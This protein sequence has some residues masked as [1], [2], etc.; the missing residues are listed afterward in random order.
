MKFVLNLI[1]IDYLESAAKMALS[2]VVLQ[3]N[4]FSIAGG[5]SDIDLPDVAE[6]IRARGVNVTLLWDRFCRDEEIERLAEQLSGFTENISSVRFADPGVGLF[7]KRQLPELNLQ[8]L[9]WDGHQNRSGI[10]KWINA[11]QPNLQRLIISNQISVQSI[12][13]LREATSTNIEIKGLGRFQLFYSE[14][15][16]L[17]NQISE[18]PG[19][20][21]RVTVASMDRPTQFFPVQETPRSTVIFND[22]DLFLLDRLDDLE[23]MGI[24]YVGLEPHTEEQYQLLASV[25]DLT[26]ESGYIREIWDRPLTSGFFD[27]NKTDVLLEKLTNPFL[28]DEKQQQIATVLESY[29]NSHI[30]I[31]LHQKLE[32]PCQVL[33]LTPE[34]KTVSHRIAGLRDLQGK[35]YWKM[36][37]KGFYLLPWIKFVVPASIM[38][39]GI[40]TNY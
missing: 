6:Q 24:D 32:L 18:N 27:E 13:S 7:L 23:K 9:M 10:I 20:H 19:E 38:K 26:A 37:N 34:R 11:F 14:R 17:H 40:V 2:E 15:S 21:H 39:K 29:R 28:K 4:R 16:L 30:L 35:E 3:C 33:F 1:S 31:H 36:A 8:F 25:R 12:K 22:N 5:I